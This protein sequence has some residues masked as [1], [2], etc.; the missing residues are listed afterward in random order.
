MPACAS[1]RRRHALQGAGGRSG[2]LS[3]DRLPRPAL[4]APPRSSLAGLLIWWQLPDEVE[5]AARTAAS[6]SSPRRESNA[7]RAQATDEPALRRQLLTEAQSSSRMQDHDDNGEMLALQADI[8]P[9][10]ACSMPYE[11]P[12]SSVSDIAQRVTGSPPRRRDR[13]RQRCATVTQT[14]ACCAF[15]SMAAAPETVREGDTTS[16]S[17]SRPGYRLGG[18]P[19]A[20]HHR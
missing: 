1:A 3:A 8:R 18:I 4:F 7:T 9:L 16:C 12:N 6:P 11:V 19:V 17:P 5:E 2:D 14:A 15:R 20:D 10:S 13:R